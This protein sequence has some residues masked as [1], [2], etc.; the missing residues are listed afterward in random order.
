MLLIK[1]GRVINPANH[2]DMYADVLI[3]EG[4]I[5]K[6]G[7]I[8]ATENMDV[9]DASD[10]IVAPGLIDNHVHFRDPG[11]TYKEDIESGS[12]AAVAGGFTT[13]VC[14]ANTAPCVDHVDVLKDILSRAEKLPVH[15]K[16]CATVTVGLKGQALVDM[17]ALK[18][19]GA[20]GFTD[21]GVPIMNE[22]LLLEAMRNAQALGLPISLH[23]EDPAFVESAGVNSGKVAK[24]I[25]VGGASHLAEEVLTARDCLLAKETGCRIDI[26][27]L[28]SGTSVDIIRFMKSLGADV[29]CEVTPQHL[30]LTEKE[31]LK[32]GALAKINP[33]F[34]REE[35]RQKLIAGLADGTI[36]MIVTDH[37][38]HAQ[39]E[40]DKGIVNGAPS[41][42]I[43]LETSLA[44]SITSLVKPGYMTIAQ[45]LEKMTVNPAD[46]YHMDA[47]RLAVGKPADLCIFDPNKEWVV[48]EDDFHGK[49][50]NSPFVGKRLLGRVMYTICDGQ[51]VY[52][53]K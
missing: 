8:E 7:K 17:P 48:S 53:L 34:R 39:Y 22:K 44:L 3:D 50:K 52:K 40:K 21:D 26:Q 35:D 20:I 25:G 5:K 13:V 33:P 49:S 41:G 12:Q 32:K 14:M 31:V 30:T 24:T 15:L 36:D 37:A 16:Q 29:W 18:E 19:A 28:S 10:L 9:I 6:I 42:M 4:I 27:H 1:N 46:Y 43:G 47:G 2:E 23:E 45:L 51:I 38:P 11:L